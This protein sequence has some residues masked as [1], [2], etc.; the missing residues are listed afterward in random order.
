MAT[1]ANHHHHNYHHNAML[2]KCEVQQTGNSVEHY[3]SIKGA[4][5]ALLNIEQ[6]LLTMFDRNILIEQSLQNIF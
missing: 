3:S 6:L 5:I 1:R 2:V 4:G